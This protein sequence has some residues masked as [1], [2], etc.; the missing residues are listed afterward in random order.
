M[1]IKSTKLERLFDVSN[2]AFLLAMS[3]LV[4]IPIL[5][6]IAGSFS[7][8]N[9]LIHSKVFIW[10]VDFNLDNFALVIQN[11]TFWKSFRVSVFLVIVGTAVNMG[12]TMLTSYPLSRKYLMGRRYILLLIVFTMIFQA[13]MVP[14]YL[15][16]NDLGLI[17]SIWSLII[18]A[19][20][21]AF[22]LI[23]CITF[24]RSLPEELFE[25]A[26]IDGMSEY[27]ILW[28]I[29]L[30]LS[31]PI[32]VTLL[33]FY[34]VQHWNSYFSALIYITDRDL[35][36]L[37]LYMYNLLADANAIDNFRGISAEAVMDT[38]PQGLQMATIVVATAPIVMIYPFIQKHFIK[39]AMLGSLKE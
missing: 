6:V 37:Q 9:A 24:F 23:L 12:L 32:T 36:P 7:S 34:A 38:S 19:A 4:V 15:L 21:N 35:Y 31:L 10:P 26:R 27:G 11:E 39:G 1:K 30:P 14:N 3:A 13:P 22:N 20:L 17:N 28:K 33:L 8:T 16:V 2:V 29:V 25:A 5:H 18:P